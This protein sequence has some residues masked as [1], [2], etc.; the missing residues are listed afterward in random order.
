MKHTQKTFKKII[1]PKIKGKEDNI[2]IGINYI[3]FDDKHFPQFNLDMNETHLSSVTIN[4]F[5]SW[6][7]FKVVITSKNSST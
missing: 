6:L 2:K 5:A 4:A 7:I 1:F 3:D